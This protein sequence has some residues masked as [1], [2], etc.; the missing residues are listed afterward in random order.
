MT[1]P[2]ADD[3]LDRERAELL[4]EMARLNGSSKYEALALAQL[5]RREEAITVARRTGSLYLLARV[6]PEHEAKAAVERLAA[7]LPDTLRANFLRRGPLIRG[8]SAS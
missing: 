2:G 1:E 7:K 5:G 6:G 4:L 3:G 8:H